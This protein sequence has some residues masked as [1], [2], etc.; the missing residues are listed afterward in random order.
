MTKHL[1]MLLAAVL[2][3][4]L[5][6]SVS[7]QR[8]VTVSG[9]DAA[10]TKPAPKPK[11][12]RKSQFPNPAEEKELLEFLRKSRRDFYNSLMAQ[13]K[14]SDRR[15]QGTLKFAWQW[16]KRYRSLD[17]AVRTEV[18]REQKARLEISKVLGK[19]KNATSEGDRKKLRSDLARLA[20]VQFDAQMKITKY[21]LDQTSNQLS[22]LRKELNNRQADR[23]KIV[24]QRVEEWL[25]A[26]TKPVKPKSSDKK[27]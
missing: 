12:K 24:A 13:K 11:P 16:Y 7:Q 10:T 23:K 15:Y 3:C 14:T 19:M 1:T 26:T 18:D 9:A 22:R 25:K 2:F 27:K 20:G 4:V 5:L 17:A 21:K 6:V 8:P